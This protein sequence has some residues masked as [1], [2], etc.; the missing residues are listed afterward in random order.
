MTQKTKDL[1]D[2]AKDG[3]LP[4]D[5]MK[6]A[7]PMN[8]AAKKKAAEAARVLTE[9]QLLQAS[10]EA[11]FNR[12]RPRIVSTGHWKIDMLTGGM[13]PGH[14]WLMA[15]E[16]SFGKSTFLVE[17]VDLEL[18]AGGRPLIVSTEDDEQIYG[19]RLMC[20]RAGV[21]AARMRDGK[22]RPEELDEISRVAAAG[23][24]Q[25]L[26][27][28]GRGFEVERLA[29]QLYEIIGDE[30]ITYVGV[31]YIQEIDSKRRHQDERLKFKYIA[32]LL[33]RVIKKRR[34]TGTLF[35]QITEQTGKKY[36]DKNSVRECKDI[37]NGAEVILIGFEP[38][39]TIETPKGETILPGSKCMKVDKAK[40][41]SKGIVVMSWDKRSASFNEVKRPVHESEESFYDEWDDFSERVAP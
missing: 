41:G 13:K 26:F 28:D 25:P 40:Q 2:R 30:N 19:D 33:R 20:R 39:E 27:L 37:S 32:G 36:P 18:A 3:E 7:K 1:N 38:Q 35:S 9:K 24:D 31:D 6:G 23:V 8:D 14:V 12:E 15:A 4:D 22:L 10:M 17:V 21:S 29:K 34:I 11:A 5:P 16:T